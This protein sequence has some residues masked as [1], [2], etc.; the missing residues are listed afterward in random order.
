M[1]SIYNKN[2]GGGGWREYIYVVEIQDL[3]TIQSFWHA[4]MDITCQERRF[5]QGMM[6]EPLSVTPHSCHRREFADYGTPS[7]TLRT[8]GIVG[9][10]SGRLASQVIEVGSFTTE[11]SDPI[12]AY[13]EFIRNIE[14]R[15]YPA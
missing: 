9:W 1:W 6:A 14:P 5:S 11:G 4:G 10:C 15:L 2:G 13:P 12:T 7:S 8:W 3:Q